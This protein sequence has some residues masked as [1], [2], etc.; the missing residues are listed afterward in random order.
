MV[1]TASLP[2]RQK[3]MQAF[4]TTL[5]DELLRSG[6]NFGQISRQEAEFLMN[7]MLNEAPG[8][9]L[10]IDVA[11]GASSS[12][13]LTALSLSAEP[14]TLIAVECLEHCYFDKNR[15]VAFLVDAVFGQ[16][17]ANYEL[18][19]GRSSFELADIMKGRKADAIFIDGNHSH[20]WACFDTLL[21]LPFLSPGARIIYHD[22]NLHLLG[23]PTKALSRGPHQLFYSVPAMD[24]VT[25]GQYPHP[26]IGALILPEDPIKAALSIFSVMFGFAWEP[27][28][29]PALNA[30]LILELGKFI[31]FH[32]GKAL[33]VVFLEQARPYLTSY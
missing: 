26:N 1:E 2:E 6:D 14:G 5:Y 8:C 11:G 3:A 20:P 13:I 15:D 10:E 24:K 27:D 12:A 9:V 25:V 32:Y 28:A 7:R 21:A 33:Q 4:L 16:K 19:K 30:P 17:P 31:G 18:H 22:I 23:G 29:W